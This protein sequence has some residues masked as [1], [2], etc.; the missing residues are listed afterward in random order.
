M[1][2]D[3]TVIP[4]AAANAQENCGA[5]DSA[6]AFKIPRMPMAGFLSLAA[7]ARVVLIV[8]SGS[9]FVTICSA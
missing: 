6:K 3:H 1:A 5:P 8:I 9:L 4:R 7:R 2:R